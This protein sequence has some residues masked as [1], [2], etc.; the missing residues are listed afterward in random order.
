MGSWP[1][2]AKSLY[3]TFYEEAFTHGTKNKSKV[4]HSV[5]TTDRKHK[6]KITELAVH[7]VTCSKKP[8]VRTE[9]N[10]MIS[11]TSISHNTT[12]PEHSVRITGFEVPV[13]RTVWPEYRYYVYPID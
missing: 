4:P 11:T 6:R 2:G 13:A 10:T 12:P 7:D 5:K 8:C 3:L 9:E 1:R